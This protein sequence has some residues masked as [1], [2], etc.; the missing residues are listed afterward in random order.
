MDFVF[1]FFY[2]ILI[3]TTLFYIILIWLNSESPWLGGLFLQNIKSKLRY[4]KRYLFVLQKKT[5]TYLKL[6]RLLLKNGSYKQLLEVIKTKLFFPVTN[7]II[8]AI[9]K[10]VEQKKII[11]QGVYANVVSKKNSFIRK[12]YCFAFFF[13]FLW[14]KFKNICHTRFRK[15]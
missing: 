9:K 12:I 8:L 6:F 3:F 5:K 13:F 10:K 2:W 7:V 11:L 14:V 4:S 15:K 1:Y